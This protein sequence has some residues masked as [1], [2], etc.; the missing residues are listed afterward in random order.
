MVEY[1]CS[2]LTYHLF[3]I[4]VLDDRFENFTY[5][6]RFPHSPRYQDPVNEWKEWKTHQI[7]PKF[8]TLGPRDKSSKYGGAPGF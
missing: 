2:D 1:L 5:Q 8:E 6:L 4:G 3:G 7:F